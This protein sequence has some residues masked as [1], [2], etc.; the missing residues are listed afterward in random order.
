M[1]NVLV[2]ARRA[3]AVGRDLAS[4]RALVRETHRVR[5]YEPRGEEKAWAAAA[6]R[7]ARG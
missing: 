2:Q 7:V 3:G 1:G 6:T 4:M 5:R